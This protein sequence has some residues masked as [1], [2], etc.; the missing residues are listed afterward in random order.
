M[1][2][3]K[4]DL[5]IRF[6]G[7]GGEG[8]ISSGDM[9]AQ[10]AVRSGLEVLT[11]K[12]FPAEIKGGYAMYQTRFA[13][14]K[15]LSEGSGFDVMV[16]FNQEALELNK[17]FLKEGN[18]LIYDY[19]GGDITEEQNIPGVHCYPVPMSKISKEDIGNYRSKNMV[20]M[21]AVAELFSISM[22]QI[23]GTIQSKFGKKG[24]DIVEMNFKALDA[25]RDHVRSN[26][27]KTDSYKMDSGKTAENTIIISGNDAVGLG[28]LMAG[29]Q[30]F[31]AY[32]IT[33]AT[34]VAYF[35]A[36]HLPKANGNLVQA[37]DEIASIA[38]VIGASYAGLKAMTSTSG[39]GLSLMQELIGM[40]S[41]MEVPV[42]ICDVQRGGPSTGLP[43][44]HEQSD[45]FLA[46]HGCHGDAPRVVL[47]PEGVED[48][49]YLTV[50][51]FNI[52]EKY[53]LP[54]M[55]LSDGS[56]GFRTASMKK[57]DPSKLRLVTREK[58]EGNGGD[59]KRYKLTES[60]V[61]PMSIP[62]TPGGAYIST[63][64]EHAE[65]SAP[66]YTADNRTAM[67][68]KRFKKLDNLEDFFQPTEADYQ[69]GA[70]IG[71]IAWGSTIGVAREAVNEARA[72]GLKVSALYP[73]LV[74]PL[75]LK[76]INKFIGK[77]KKILI[78]EVNKQGQ[79]AKLITG[80]TGCVPISYTIYGGMPFTPAMIAEK[81]K[82]ISK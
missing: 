39:P 20:C 79:L 62:G 38:N 70:E 3:K 66:R 27:K 51:A 13:H 21:G 54:V 22:E 48:C 28:A 73:K 68:D 29:V 15:I 16:A 10:A 4:T 61:S 50:E 76:A 45:L 67:M 56:L 33:P 44:K 64:L 37:E 57:P 82:E 42:V 47:S 40:A 5:I 55:V 60:G 80:E 2:E 77:H 52:A 53:Q 17:K 75:P 32:P 71:V 30:Y 24:A 41:M 19:P 69:D 14:D 8:I 34:E 18:A 7:E 58:Y 49:V 78:P 74:W 11:F 43:T 1:A 65:S 12:T 59:F 36:R 46:A 31:S 35:L 23:R 9:V 26:I 6:G 25:G 81:I 72:A 63:G